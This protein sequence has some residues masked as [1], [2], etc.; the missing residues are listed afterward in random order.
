MI[1]DLD[2]SIEKLLQLELGP[3]LPFDLSFAIPDRNFSPVSGTKNTVGC[4]LYDIREDRELRRVEPSLQRRADGTVVRKFPPA[5]VLLSYCITVWSPAALTPATAPTLDE[6]KVLS[7]VLRVFLKYPELPANILVGALAGQQPPLPTTTILPDIAKSVNDF[8]TSLGGQLRPS[9]DYK[10]TLSLDYRALVSGPLVTTQINRY[11][12]S[13]ITGTMD[14][15]IQIGGM[16][17]DQAAPPN[18]IPNAW[19]RLDAAGRTEI[20]DVAGRFI[21]TGV[22]RGPHVL[23]VRAVGF[24]DAVRGISVPEPTG[25]YNVTLL[26]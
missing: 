23:Q 17:L 24:Q 19:V 8:W 5:R 13:D 25:D 18:P 12:S 22:T 26:P 2:R 21:F 11:G 16:V 3:V 6:H 10:I 20:T 1:D 7:D 4:Y 15:Q 14:E 9:L